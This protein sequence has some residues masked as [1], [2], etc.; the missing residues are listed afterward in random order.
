VSE[1][2]DTDHY[3]KPM[4]REKIRV[5]IMII[6]ILIN[7]TKKYLFQYRTVL[8]FALGTKKPC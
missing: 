4:P 6:N 3:E 8:L 1:L 5:K 2:I 7:Q